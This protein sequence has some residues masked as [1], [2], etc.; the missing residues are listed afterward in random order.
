[1]MMCRCLRGGLPMII[2]AGKW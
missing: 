2:R 1:L